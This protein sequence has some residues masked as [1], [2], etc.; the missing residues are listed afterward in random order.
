M[1]PGLIGKGSE[2]V[3]ELVGMAFSKTGVQGREGTSV[4]VWSFQNKSQVG[5][6]VILLK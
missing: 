2:N 1:K 6:W 4:D 5:K 3:S